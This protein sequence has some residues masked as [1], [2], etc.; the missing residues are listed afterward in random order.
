MAS[1]YWPVVNY[2]VSR[3]HSN[4][5]INMYNYSSYIH[6]IDLYILLQADNFELNQ[7]TYGTPLITLCNESD[8][9]SNY[10]KTVHH[11]FEIL[12]PIYDF[13]FV[14][15]NGQCGT[16]ILQFFFTAINEANRDNYTLIT[17]CLRIRD[18]I[19]AAEW[20]IV[21]VFFDVSL[22]DCSSFGEDAN[23]VTARA[24]TLSCPDDFGE[25]CGS[26][27]QPLC[28]EI[29]IFDDTAT[30][31]YKVLN[32]ILHSLSLIAGVV[33]FLAC[34]LYKKKM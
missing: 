15:R 14:T 3:Y 9:C 34:C 25:Y 19:C 31:V 22:P 2:I 27:C 11:E 33:T 20:R 12:Q 23:F 26:L 7:D 8:V 30:T 5:Q 28:D 10:N 16:A 18:D 4:F 6:I 13:S 21:E 32:I 24:P 17:D 29:S 1:K